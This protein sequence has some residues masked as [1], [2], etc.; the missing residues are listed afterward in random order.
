MSL[1]TLGRGVGWLALAILLAANLVLGARLQNQAAPPDERDA[2]YEKM[3]LFTRVLE[4]VREQYVDADKTS[5]QDLIYGALRGMLESLDPHSQFLDPDMYKDM[6]DET[7]GEFGGLGI[8]IGVKEGMLTVIAP[9]EDTPGFKAGLLPGDKIL[10]IDG[11]PTDNLTI[12]EAVKKLRGAPGTKV[13][14]GI[15]RPKSEGIRTLELARA[16]I[17]IPSVKDTDMLE[18]G[19]GYL[20]IVQFNEPTAKAVHEAVQGLQARGLRAL[21][22]DLRN[23]P[24]G[25]L[26]SAIEVAE[27][28]VRRGDMIVFTQGRNEKPLQTFRAKGRQHYTDFPMVIL[29]NGG[30]ASAAE[31]VAGALQDHR[32]AILVGEKSFGKGSVQS[33]L[34]LDD[35]SAIRLTTARYYT[36]S[37]R[38]I[39]EQGIEPDVPVAMPPED[40]QQLINRRAG[41]E[42][43]KG[44]EALPASSIRDVQ[45]D[46]AVDILKG[47]MIFTAQ[48]RT[49]AVARR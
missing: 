3:A 31:I 22:L 32:R 46:R 9:M 13:T 33:V 49:S 25:L 26:T 38:V 1:R 20:R 5:Y 36:P 11:K 30:S 14:L 34:Q 45:L 12:E 37:K 27:K 17:N 43:G 15:L 29:I 23:N 24:G 42:S 19:I 44:E 4:Q 6:K 47:V 16:I 40:L 18:D 41:L 39:H 35:G 10:E 2:G 8:V 48:Q 21:V 7:A 28:F